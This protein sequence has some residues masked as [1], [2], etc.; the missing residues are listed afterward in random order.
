MS[1]RRY[2]VTSEE[3]ALAAPTVRARFAYADR[4]TAY[5][6]ARDLAGDLPPHYR[7][8]VAEILEGQRTAAT[9]TTTTEGTTK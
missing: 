9:T 7:V 8:T 6:F 5:R 2:L 3:G 1:N 4:D